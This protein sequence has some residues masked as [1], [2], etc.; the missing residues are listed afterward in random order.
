MHKQGDHRIHVE[1]GDFNSLEF[2]KV[3]EK[4]VVRNSNSLGMNEQEI[5]MI[6]EYWKNPKIQKFTPS[7]S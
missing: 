4:H 5:S 6:L 1:F 7:S 3:F 2:F